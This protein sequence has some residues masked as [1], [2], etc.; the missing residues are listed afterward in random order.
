MVPAEPSSLGVGLRVVVVTR[1]D[2][3][4]PG[5]D[6]TA[7]ARFDEAT[8]LIH[9]RHFAGTGGAAGGTQVFAVAHMVFAGQHGD[10]PRHF[11]LAIGLDKHR[12]PQRD[13]FAQFVHGHRRRAVDHVFQ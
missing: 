8:F 10:H 1:R 9:Q 2:Q 13:A 5:D 4:T 11:G 6:F 7:L 3:F 12:P